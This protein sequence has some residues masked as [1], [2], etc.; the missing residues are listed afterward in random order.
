MP[1]G[2]RTI[3]RPSRPPVPHPTDPS[4]ALV[5]LTRGQF[6]VISAVD[7][8]AVSHFKWRCRRSTTSM[9]AV[10]SDR[11]AIFHLHRV[12]AEAMG[13]DMSLT[14]DHINGNGLDCR[15]SNLR[16]ATRSQ[17]KSNS[18]YVR[19]SSGVRGVSR[20][21]NGRWVVHVTANRCT[22]YLGTFDTIEEAAQVRREAAL[23]YQ[24][25]FAA[26]WRMN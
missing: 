6:A 21:K 5:P 24:G 26:E 18:T 7:V 17:N 9:Y 14:I 8:M 4:L 2:I 22:H 13:L 19:A 15:R 3:P 16:S 1:T 12:V 25:Q 10:A 20:T 23:Q 11:N